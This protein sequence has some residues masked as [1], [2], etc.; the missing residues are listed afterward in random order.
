M[1][2]VC[3]AAGAGGGCAAEYPVVGNSGRLPSPVRLRSLHHRR[4]TRHP[5]RWARRARTCSL[6]TSS[7]AFNADICC[8]CC[9]PVRTPMKA[10]RCRS[11]NARTSSREISP[12]SFNA[13]ILARCC[14]CRDCSCSF[15]PSVNSRVAKPAACPP[16]SVPFPCPKRPRASAVS[17]PRRP[18]RPN[19]SRAIRIRRVIDFL[20]VEKRWY[21]SVFVIPGWGFSPAS[22][23]SCSGRESLARP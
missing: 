11:L 20:L 3:Y 9:S 19:P 1:A 15:R 12:N 8:R 5:G 23:L 14:W 10:S 16:P 22:A 21:P 13:C 7:E 18:A 4:R 2:P 17:R 6:P